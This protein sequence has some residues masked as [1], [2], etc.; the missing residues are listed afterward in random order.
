MAYL[1]PEFFTENGIRSLRMFGSRLR[2]TETTDS[3]VDLL[4]DFEAGY[5]VGYFELTRIQLDLTDRL[6][7]EVDLRTPAELS[8]RFRQHVV[9]GAKILYDR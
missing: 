6:G 9:R 5:H 2:G 4:V 3:D 7:V 8:H 1:P